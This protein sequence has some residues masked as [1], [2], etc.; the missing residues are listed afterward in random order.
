MKITHEKK[1]FFRETESVVSK[2]VLL[3]VCDLHGYHRTDS[4][5]FYASYYKQ[6]EIDF[7]NEKDKHLGKIFFSKIFTYHIMCN[8]ICIRLPKT[9]YN[10][11]PF[12]YRAFESCCKK[13]KHYCDENEIKLILTPVFGREIL[14]GNWKTILSILEKYFPDFHLVVYD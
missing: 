1:K 4:N 9:P 13:L 11:V 3:N 8:M 6:P 5:H 7:K 12:R 10:L 2:K 14:E